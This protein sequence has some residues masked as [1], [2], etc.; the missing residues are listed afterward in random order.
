M[1][2]SHLRHQFHL[3][4][5]KIIGLTA[6]LAI[7]LVVSA[8]A[9]AQKMVVL[10]NKP[11]YDDALMHYGF[12]LAASNAK[13]KINH[14]Q[15]YID[16]IASQGG[17]A[18]A[19]NSPAFSTG[20]ILSLRLN[21]YMNLR[22]L[23]GVSFYG[24]SIEYK[25]PGAEAPVVAEVN[26]TVIELP[27]LVKI[28]SERRKNTAM[29]FIAGGRAGVDVSSRRKDRVENELRAE[30]D[31]LSID[32]GVGVDLYYPFFKFAPEL[33]FSHGLTNLLVPDPN[34]FSR[35]LDKMTTHTVTLYLNFE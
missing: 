10:K 23:P 29:Y 4:G 7:I 27:L 8:P 25:L 9:S 14:S 11:G 31:N 21:D 35:S 16:S 17:Y 15:Y 5:Q 13:F 20:F 6:V 32:Y 19:K 28:R 1:A 2:F 3:Y 12:Y 24:R 18:H 26:S 34:P 22:F 30:A 33:R